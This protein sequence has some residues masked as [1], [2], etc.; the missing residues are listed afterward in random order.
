MFVCERE[1][2]CV[3]ERGSVSVHSHSHVASLSCGQ[4]C[5]EYK[6]CFFAGI[7]L[8]LMVRPESSNP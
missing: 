6:N 2:V 4:I 8:D 5:V 7:S 3:R 1:S